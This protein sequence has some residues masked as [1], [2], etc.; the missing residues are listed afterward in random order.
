MT[1]WTDKHYDF[2]YTLTEKDI[3]QG[4]IK[5]DPYFI[6]KQW[7]VGSKDDSGALFHILKTV[8]RFGDKNDIER[9]VK[10][11]HAQVLGV[12]RSFGINLEP[13]QTVQFDETIGGKFSNPLLYPDDSVEVS[14][15][16]IN[17]DTVYIISELVNGKLVRKI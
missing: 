1:Q 10:A 7:K 4:S 9:E 17:S 14:A 13:P 3:E 6:S 16:A 5:L 8:A 12:A 15:R 2:T 11:L